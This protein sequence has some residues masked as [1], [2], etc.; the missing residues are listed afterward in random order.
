MKGSNGHIVVRVYD[1]G[2]KYYVV[3]VSDSDEKMTVK[4]IAGPYKSK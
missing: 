3:T 2:A 4:Q 1:G